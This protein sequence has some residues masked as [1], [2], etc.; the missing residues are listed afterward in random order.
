[1]L[2]WCSSGVCGPIHDAA[3]DGD[4][5][6]VKALLK[7]NPRLVASRNSAGLTPLHLAASEGHAD[8]VDLLLESGADVNA[9]TTASANPSLG[10]VAVGGGV[11]LKLG[12]RI[13]GMTPLHYAAQWG[14]GPKGYKDV[15]E[16]LLAHGAT[17]NARD[18]YGKTPW[19]YAAYA[20]HSEVAELLHQ[21][22]GDE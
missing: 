5:D 7:E 18:S 13:H 21:H 6:K 14:Y 1:L 8:I 10:G 9:N 2:A 22:G 19:H 4:L 20:G 11:A 15:V 3:R 16:L 12:A 17:V